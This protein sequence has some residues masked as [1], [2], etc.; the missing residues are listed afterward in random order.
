[1]RAELRRQAADVA[2]AIGVRAVMP[3]ITTLLST[4][5]GFTDD[6]APSES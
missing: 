4:F 6:P 5:Y 1:M 3:L 2:A